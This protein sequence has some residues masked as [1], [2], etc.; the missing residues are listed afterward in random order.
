MRDSADNKG[1][2]KGEIMYEHAKKVLRKNMKSPVDRNGYVPWP[3]E[4]LIPGVKLDQFEQDLREGAGQE[5]R[6]KFCAVHSSAALVVNTFAPFKNRPEDLVLQGQSGFSRPT[7]EKTLETGLGGTP[8]TLDVFLQKDNEVIGVESKFLEYFTPKQAEFSDSYDPKNL[9]WAED[10]WWQVLE[11]ARKAGK[12]NLDV[13]QLV[14]H[15][16]GLSRLLHRGEAT[17]ATLLYLFWEPINASDLAVCRQHRSEI[18]ELANQVANSRVAFKWMSYP[19]LWQEWNTV[20]ALTEH[21]E[22]LKRR[23]EVSL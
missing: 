15:Y 23:Y 22:N 11:D 14:K 3:Q 2:V 6:M 9:P 1:Q 12:R 4:N 13:A 20:P 18:E 7:F 5:L 19:E 17:S 10:Y 16:F 21:T 8:P